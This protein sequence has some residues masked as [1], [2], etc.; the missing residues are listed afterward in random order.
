MSPAQ[1][2]L[3]F[4]ATQ[5]SAIAVQNSTLQKETGRWVYQRPAKQGSDCNAANLIPK[6]SELRFFSFPRLA[7]RCVEMQ[8]L[9]AFLRQWGLSRAEFA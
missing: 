9:L 6:A 8:H 2:S 3:T 7:T 1:Y 4:N 5:G